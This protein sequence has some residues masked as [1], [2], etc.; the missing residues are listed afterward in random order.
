[1]SHYSLSSNIAHDTMGCTQYVVTPNA[2][3]AAQRIVQD[4][5]EGKRAFHLVGTYGT[6]KSTFLLQ[7]E[8]DLQGRGGALLVGTAAKWCGTK[9]CAVLNVV[10]EY[11]ALAQLLCRALEQTHHVAH[12]P[13]DVSTL[14]LQWLEEYYAKVAARNELLVIAIDEFGKTLEHAAQHEVESELFFVQ[15]LAEWCNAPHRNV[16]LLLSMHQHFATYGAQL[17]ERDR[18]EWKK[19]QGRFSEIEFKEPPEQLLLLAV[20]T[21]PRTGD[22]PQRTVDALFSVARESYLANAMFTTEVATRLFP[23]DACAAVVLTRALQ[24]Y[25]QNSRSIFSLLHER[26]EGSLRDFEGKERRCYSLNEVFLYLTT[27]FRSA[28][29]EAHADALGWQAMQLATERVE[30]ADWPSHTQLV[31]AVKVVRTI[32]LLHLFG[33]GGLKMNHELL[34]R[35]LEW[36]MDM[37]GASAV[38]HSLVQ[39]RIIRFAD[40][41][42]HY[43]LFEGTDFNIEGEVAKATTMVEQ[44]TALADEI[45]HYLP[46]TLISVRAHSYRTGTPRT[47]VQRCVSAPHDWQPEGAT[48]GFLQL[49]V[50]TGTD[51]LAQV[52]TV[53]AATKHANVYVVCQSVEEIVAHL[54]R[55]KVYHHVLNDVIKDRSDRVAV[56]ELEQ[57]LQHEHELLQQHLQS[58]LTMEQKVV[59]VY[60]GR[61]ATVED[62]RA[63]QELLSRVCDEVYPFTPVVRNEL[64]N[65]HKLSSNISTA[66]VKF[67]QAM[68][69]H[70]HEADFGMESSKFPPEK[71]IY[72][73]LLHETGLHAEGGF[74]DAPTAE[75]ILPLWRASDDFLRSTTEKPRT[76]A[77]L[78]AVLAAAPYK[79][80]QGLL[81]FW[82]PTFLFM[83]RLDFS[84]FGREG[85]YLRELNME[86]LELMKKYPAEFSLKAYAESGVKI[87]LFNQYRKFLQLDTTANVDGEKFIE[88]IKPFFFFYRH[89]N[90]YAKRTQRFD[91]RSTLVF[92]QVLAQAKDP[93]QAFLEDM[94]LALGFDPEAQ[95]R[96]D[97]VRSYSAM[98]AQ[99]VHE[100]KHCYTALIDRIEA[101]LVAHLEWEHSAYVDYVADLRERWQPML[102]PL[103][104]PEQKNF[105]GHAM[106]QFERRT[107][108]Y[109]SIAFSVLG[110]PLLQLTDA[111]EQPL[112]QQLV[113]LFEECEAKAVLSRAMQ[114]DAPEKK[115]EQVAVL[116]RNISALLTGHVAIDRKALVKLLKQQLT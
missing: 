58:L 48:D 104:S 84:L 23:L 8:R 15:Q 70:E 31:D 93:E 116:E 75:S 99:A 86:C 33:G 98:I 97:F 11:V 32:G 64:V 63:L 26:G 107:D 28:L 3:Q 2:Q 102:Q 85:K 18:Q 89:L 66:R 105:V 30:T 17:R 46:E 53:S 27:H 91:H 54:H 111:E 1:M 50:S 36:S 65:R 60:G 44:P 43:V 113:Y 42:G 39:R 10:G 71:T 96:D 24:R 101:Q 9:G 14:A 95:Q 67:L 52:K 109:Q 5:R 16:M 94:P 115:S 79:A 56:R 108:W 69:A 88:T 55:I 19:V 62:H 47:F 20:Q 92:R 13:A 6:G 40:Y 114:L 38:L 41:R 80:K 21:M 59:W 87:D 22:V 51:V 29:H 81:D 76:V 100:L 78:Q 35:Y 77:E 57:Q 25:G 72:R 106:A 12:T 68:L 73:A 110:K 83:R 82:I 34:A 45:A 4:F 49:V 103:L 7:F 74:H 61:E 112:I 37:A 90:D